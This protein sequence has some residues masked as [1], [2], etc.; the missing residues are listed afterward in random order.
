[1][2]E[3]FDITNILA[4]LPENKRPIFLGRFKEASRGICKRFPRYNSR[5]IYKGVPEETSCDF[6]PQRERIEKHFYVDDNEVSEDE[7]NDVVKLTDY[8]REARHIAL[9][10]AKLEILRDMESISDSIEE[11]SAYTDLV[12]EDPNLI[13]EIAQFLKYERQKNMDYAEDNAGIEDNANFENP[14]IT[15]FKALCEEEPQDLHQLEDMTGLDKTSID[16]SLRE[17]EDEGIVFS[18]YDDKEFSAGIF[19]QRR[20]YYLPP[21]WRSSYSIVFNSEL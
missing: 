4:M 15:L 2:E 13:P 16:N 14:A 9:D 19:I 12:P 20:V 3:D 1:M 8:S 10:E 5:V 17:L 7:Y 21:L 6:F 11:K 18:R